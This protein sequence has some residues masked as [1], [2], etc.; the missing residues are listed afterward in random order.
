VLTVSKKVFK[1]LISN[2]K[3]KVEKSFDVIY[4][5]YSLL[6]YYVALKITKSQDLSQDVLNETFFSFYTHRYD[7]RDYKTIKYYLSNTAKNISLN[8]LRRLQEAMPLEDVA[9]P[10]QVD[11]YDYF[12]IYINKFKD[13]LDKEEIDLVIYHLFYDYT[14]KE[15]ADMLNVSINA[16]TSKYHR[17]IE[18]LKKHYGDDYEKF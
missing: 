17:T 6:V 18:K 9:E 13:F 2:N 3:D 14:F 11:E 1:D 10:I 4:K 7:I 15:I 8:I 12:E 16:I 5:E